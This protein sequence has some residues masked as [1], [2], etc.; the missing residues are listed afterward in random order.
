MGADVITSDNHVHSL[1]TCNT[2]YALH[3]GYRNW[4]PEE[5]LM[6]L[7]Q[8]SEIL[9]THAGDPVKTANEIIRSS[10]PEAALSLVHLALHSLDERIRMQSSKAI[11]D[12]T[13]NAAGNAPVAPLD[14]FLQDILDEANK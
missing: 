14:K 5:A 2:C 8:E 3:M 4:D 10:A 11:L 6:R 13:V 1:S 9:S 7:A 12:M